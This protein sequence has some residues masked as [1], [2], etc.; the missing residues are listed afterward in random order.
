MAAELP[1]LYYQSVMRAAMKLKRTSLVDQ[2]VDQLRSEI[3]YGSLTP[4]TPLPETQVSEWLGIARPTVREVLL[5]L[6]NEGLVQGRGRGLAFMVSRISREQLVDI[7]TAR[8]HI[9]TAGA[10][11]Y[12]EADQAS[13]DA[14]A[15]SVDALEAAL[16]SADRVKQIQL[17]HKCHAATVALT[18]SRRLTEVHAQLLTESRLAVITAGLSDDNI[19]PLSHRE[20]VDLLQEGRIEAACDQLARRLEV[21]RDHAAQRL[22]E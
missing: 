6:Q 16:E 3:I 8:L 15:D 9:E 7:Y 19:V 18:G 2:A 13:R 17:D 21:A 22:P 11:S 1:P 12:G 10:R 20:F 14:L 5:R 4:G